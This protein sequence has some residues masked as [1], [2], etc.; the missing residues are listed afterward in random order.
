[1]DP[2]RNTCAEAASISNA[3]ISK[4][5]VQTQDYCGLATFNALPSTQSTELVDTYDPARISQWAAQSASATGPSTM[6]DFD[7]ELASATI[8]TQIPYQFSE[9]QSDAFRSVQ[10][11]PPCVP[12]DLGI[13]FED[14][15][16]TSAG[17][18]FSGF[19]LDQEGNLGLGFDFSSNLNTDPYASG[20][21]S[22]INDQAYSAVAPCD[23]LNFDPMEAQSLVMTGTNNNGLPLSS[24]WPASGVDVTESL[25]WSPASALTPSSSS[26]R[27][28]D[29]RMGHPDT[30]ISA[31]PHE[32]T[33]AVD[34]SGILKC[35]NAVVSSF[36][37]REA[38]LPLS[39][40][41]HINPER[42]ALS[43]E[44]RAIR[45]SN[46]YTSTVRPGQNLQRAPLSMEFCTVQ[47]PAGH[48]FG[49]PLMY[50]GTNGSRRSS[51]GEAK[52]AR[53][54][55]YYTVEAKEDGL[56]YCPYANTENCTHKPEK[57]K[58]NYQ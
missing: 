7:T 10:F 58:C 57:L 38:M 8:A 37:P 12:Y 6:Q 18:D 32:G 47:E 56:Y 9:S 25:E 41:S 51:E 48:P 21:S 15:S 40:M 55:P 45:Q 28:S 36:N 52:V 23:V 26:M 27:T 42:F 33:L 1:M 44:T 50:R 54:H 53:D 49:I 19:Q 29:S 35:E 16:I 5:P 31:F 3:Q 11:G 46:K 17:T 39:S 2:M 30:P 43:T 20:L 4:G 34:Y 14:P 24:S 22:S 13:N